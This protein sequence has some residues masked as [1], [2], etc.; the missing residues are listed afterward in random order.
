MTF[1]GPPAS[2]LNL[3]GDTFHVSFPTENRVCRRFFFAAHFCGR[4]RTKQRKKRGIYGQ[5]EEEKEKRA[6]CLHRKN[7]GLTTYNSFKCTFSMKVSY[8]YVQCLLLPNLCNR[9]VH[10][11]YLFFCL[12][13]PRSNS[14]GIVC[15]KWRKGREKK[16]KVIPPSSH[17]GKTKERW[18]F[19]P[20]AF[21]IQSLAVEKRGLSYISESIYFCLQHSKHV[22]LVCHT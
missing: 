14:P 6:K 22:C 3:E 8:S 18:V 20:L 17:P 19:P 9:L 5:V 12:F 16:Q 13:F 11:F 4:K 7:R 10:F 1:L 21:P 2:T 15:R